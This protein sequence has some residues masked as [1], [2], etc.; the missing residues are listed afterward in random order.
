MSAIVGV[1]RLQDFCMNINEDLR[2]SIVTFF[3]CLLLSDTL[4]GAGDRERRDVSVAAT[5]TQKPR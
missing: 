4:S 2:G 1:M 3:F 5:H